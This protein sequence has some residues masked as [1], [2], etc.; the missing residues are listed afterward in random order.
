MRLHVADASVCRLIA[1]HADMRPGFTVMKT[2]LET[3]I[4]NRKR[5]SATHIRQ[6]HQQ[7][8]NTGTQRQRAACESRARTAIRRS[9]LSPIV[10][11]RAWQRHS[12]CAIG[13]TAHCDHPDQRQRN[14]TRR[15]VHLQAST[16]TG[17]A[18]AHH[19]KE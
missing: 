3:H 7:R 2:A 13:S 5:H 10:S 17:S 12:S 19:L 9:D 6:L 18:S 11:K 4:A 1:L 14:H 16:F 8:R 15:R